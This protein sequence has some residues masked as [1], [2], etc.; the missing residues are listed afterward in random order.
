MNVQRIVNR[1]RI[2]KPYTEEQWQSILSLGDRV[3]ADLAHGDVRL[4]VGGEPTFV[5]SRYPD[6]GEWNTRALGGQK[7]ILADELE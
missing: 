5:S 1:P 6:A 7:A 4:S 3:D 2:T